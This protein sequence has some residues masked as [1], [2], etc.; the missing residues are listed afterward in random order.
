MFRLLI[1]TLVFITGCSTTSELNPMDHIS[2][3]W[4]FTEKGN[5]Y[6]N[7]K[8]CIFL[9]SGELACSI[10]EAGFANGYGDAESYQTKGSWWIKNDSLILIET[11][12]FNLKQNLNSQYS[13]KS[14]TLSKI[15]LLNNNGATEVWYKKD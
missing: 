13:F 14:F 4:T 1:L 7:R 8:N 11:P 5:D 12:T 10:S 3:E 15:I 6:E 2:G 9:I